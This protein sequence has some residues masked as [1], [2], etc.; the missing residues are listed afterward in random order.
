MICPKCK[1]DVHP[2][3]VVATQKIGEE[4]STWA[5]GLFI[6]QCPRCQS[7]LPDDP[8]ESIDQDVVIGVP[9]MLVEAFEKPVVEERTLRLIKSDRPPLKKVEPK[10]DTALDVARADLAA[11]DNEI[12]AAIGDIERLKSRLVVAKAKRKAHL[13]IVTLLERTMVELK[14]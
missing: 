8:A 6:N 10:R 5:N 13:K 9:G 11:I 2:A 14:Q 3:Q 12:S 7:L 1:V 4:S